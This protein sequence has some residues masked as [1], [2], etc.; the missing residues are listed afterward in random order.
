L[1]KKMKNRKW[2]TYTLGA[3]LT[4][5]VLAAVG[6]VGFRLGMMQNASF[7]RPSF[8]RG[9]N[10]ERPLMQGNF[11]DNGKP[12]TMQENLQNNG[13]MQGRQ[14]NFNEQRFDR[15]GGDRHDGFMSLFSL[16]SHLIPLAVLALIF[17][18]VYKLVK[19]SGWRLTRVAAAS[20]VPAVG[21][22]V[23]QKKESE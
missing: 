11:Q 23:E 5:V 18:L 22:V 17:W 16:F 13:W 2:L 19:M 8:A 3:L 10:G 7:A 6:G 9:F 21:D 15:F 20:P 14:G 12:Q 1:E 4:L